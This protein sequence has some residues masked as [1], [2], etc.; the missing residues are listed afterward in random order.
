MLI[1]EYQIVDKKQ[2]LAYE[3]LAI[4]RTK[5]CCNQ[6]AALQLISKNSMARHHFKAIASQQS[7]R[8]QANKE[9]IIAQKREYYQKNQQSIIAQKRDYYKNNKQSMLAKAA[10]KVEC[11]CGT[12]IRKSD[13]ADHRKTAK[14]ARLLAAQSQ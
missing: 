12:M 7:D 3:Q 8:Y 1:K 6:I 10:I 13:I 14:H 11:E 2:L 9:S 5:S 4:S